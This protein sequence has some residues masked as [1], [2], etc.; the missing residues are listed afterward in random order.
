MKVAN[1]INNFFDLCESLPDGL[2]RF[3][4]M[5][6]NWYLLEL[7]RYRRHDHGGGPDGDDW[8][9]DHEIRKDYD[10]GAK[11][12]KSKLDSTN[13]ELSKNGFLPNADFYHSDKGNFGIQFDLTVDPEKVLSGDSK[14]SAKSG[15]TPNIVNYLKDKIHS[16]VDKNRWTEGGGP[17]NSSARIA[18]S[19]G[20]S[21]DVSLHIYMTGFT[22]YYNSNGA[23]NGS[24][25]SYTVP[26]KI[27][28]KTLDS[29]ADKLIRETKKFAS[30]VVK[31]DQKSQF[32]I[33]SFM[34]D[35]SALIKERS[36]VP[37]IKKAF[38]G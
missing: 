28:G 12:Y 38:H 15:F 11:K 8:L 29:I 19:V 21:R 17:S 4:D 25:Y 36:K 7:D 10:M 2:G 18:F 35:N 30:D 9:D 13:A 32:Y 33:G 1:K 16:V 26:F 31:D 6:D 37:E 5:G 3:K 27:Q 22:F 24:K 20:G 14:I 23:A 34:F